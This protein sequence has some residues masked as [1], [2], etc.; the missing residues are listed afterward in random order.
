LG[1]IYM[2]RKEVKMG[3]KASLKEKLGK[4]ATCVAATYGWAS[5]SSY[6]NGYAIGGFVLVSGLGLIYF[7]KGRK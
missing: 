5:A 3:L 1:I 2:R 4:V 7:L 6:I